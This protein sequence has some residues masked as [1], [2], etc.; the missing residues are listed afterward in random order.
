MHEL[1]V[2]ENI[3]A[4]ALRYAG[5]ANAT[6]ITDLHLVIGQMASIIDDSVQF[7]WDIVAKGTPAEGATLHFERIP[8]RF[9]C[10]ACQ[11]TF[12]YDGNTY[13]CPRCSSLQVQLIQGD[14]FRLESID[15]ET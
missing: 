8:A 1:A 2:T 5:Q 13:S 15:I 9:A 10:R 14:E 6:S 4:T 7:Y 12:P 3:L 11:E